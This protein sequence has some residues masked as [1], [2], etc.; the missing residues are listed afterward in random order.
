MSYNVDVSYLVQLYHDDNEVDYSTA[1]TA[2]AI[3]ATAAALTETTATVTKTV[4]PLSEIAN[5]T[6]TATLLQL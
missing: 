4:P 1:A 3:T 5:G 2:T 6:F